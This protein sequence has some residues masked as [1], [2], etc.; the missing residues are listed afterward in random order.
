[1]KSDLDT[2]TNAL[3]E[4]VSSSYCLV[5]GKQPTSDA[6]RNLWEGTYNW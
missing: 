5:T 1:M 6:R 2:V 3:S 4:Q